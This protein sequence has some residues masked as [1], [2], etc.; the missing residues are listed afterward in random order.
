MQHQTVMSI[1]YIP[2][3]NAPEIESYP[4]PEALAH[5]YDGSSGLECYYP[6]SDT[7]QSPHDASEKNKILGLKQ[8][9]FWI[10]TIAIMVISAAVIGGSV[11]GSLAIQRSR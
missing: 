7:Q 2:M 10:L 1:T 3:A 4:Y 11:G 9:A 5:K 6:P 8:R